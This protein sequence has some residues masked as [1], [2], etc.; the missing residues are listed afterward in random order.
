[1]N[2]ALIDIPEQQLSVLNEQQEILFQCRVNTARNGIGCLQNSGCTPLGK[3]YVRAC[4]G[5]GLSPY[6]VLKG[7]RP[8]GEE[9]TTDLMEANPERDWILG[10]ILWLCG[11]EVGLNRGGLVDTFRR[12][13]YI[14]GSPVW[15]TN[16]LPSSHGCV[17]VGPDDMLRVFH[18]LS[19]GSSVSLT[20]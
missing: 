8:T 1:M 6:A 4:I 9:W 16:A 5:E 15:S 14:H 18:Y 7:R 10:R 20:A 12:Y 3:H 2:C 11:Q 13:I 19:Y 17:R